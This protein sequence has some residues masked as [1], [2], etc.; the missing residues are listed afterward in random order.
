[1]LVPNLNRVNSKCP[2]FILQKEVEEEVS[3]PKKKDSKKKE[4][5]YVK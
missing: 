3:K 2:W 5:K 4:E 1:M